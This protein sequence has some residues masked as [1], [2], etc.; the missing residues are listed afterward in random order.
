VKWYRDISIP[1]NN[2]NISYSKDGKFAVIPGSRIEKETILNHIYLVSLEDKKVI[3]N[4][5]PNNEESLEYDMSL[6]FD[7]RMRINKKKLKD[8]DGVDYYFNT[9]NKTIYQ[10]ENKINLSPI[11]N[12][13]YEDTI[14]VWDEK[15]NKMLYYSKS[16][17]LRLK[18]LFFDTYKKVIS[19]NN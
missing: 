3:Y 17:T 2:F 8:T 6:F 9:K 1:T 10:K 13:S 12:I 11:S 19:L 5:L 15:S 16:D 7:E 4:F 14:N 18:V